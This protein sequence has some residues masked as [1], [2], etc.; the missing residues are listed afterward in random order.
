MR[1]PWPTGGC[2]AKDKQTNKQTNKQQDIFREHL[3][4]QSYK[5]GDYAKL[6]SIKNAIRGNTRYKKKIII[7]SFSVKPSLHF[8]Q[9]P[10]KY[11]TKNFSIV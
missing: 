7:I 11:P 4:F 9:L 8:M 3:Q 5:H 1:R 10:R 6:S 2:H